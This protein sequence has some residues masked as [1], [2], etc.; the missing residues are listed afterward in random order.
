MNNTSVFESSLLGEK[1]YRVE[2][3]SGLRIYVFPKERTGTY[4]IFSTRFGGA[5][6][7]YKYGEK[8]F[9]IP[10]GCAHFLEHKMFDNKNRP[11]ADDIFSRVPKTS[12]HVLQSC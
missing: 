7:K 2:H 6:S 12:K 4:A 1:Y 5:V 10:L 8:Y 11:G 3:K 9:E